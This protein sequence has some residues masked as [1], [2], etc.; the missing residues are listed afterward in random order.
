VDYS[1]LY[2]VIDLERP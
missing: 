1:D 2:K